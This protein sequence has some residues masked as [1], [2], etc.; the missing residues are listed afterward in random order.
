[1]LRTVSDSE[2]GGLREIIPSYPMLRISLNLFIAAALCVSA[3]Q[4]AP[5]RGR[6]VECAYWSN[7][8]STNE[9]ELQSRGCRAHITNGKVIVDRATLSELDFSKEGLAAIFV[10]SLGWFFVKRDGTTLRSVKF[11]NGPD[12]FSEGLSRYVENGKI[13]FI[14]LSGQ[15]VIEAQYGFAF[16][17]KNGHSRVCNDFKAVK[18]G[19]YHFT[20]SNRW[21]FIDRKGKLILSMQ[22]SEEEAKAK[23]MQWCSGSTADPS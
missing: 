10:K 16:P 18:S 3:C 6:P 5:S 13:G 2:T 7:A 4:S 15:V 11:E 14:D 12:S 9:A 8:A 17:F 22:Y 21:G 20:S 19:E 23:E 1:M